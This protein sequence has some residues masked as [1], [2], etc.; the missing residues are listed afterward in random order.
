[1]NYLLIIFSLS[2]ILMACSGGDD[3]QVQ[4]PRVTQQS[5][6]TPP[7]SIDGPVNPANIPTGIYSVDKMHTYLTFSYLHL[8]YSYPLLRVTGIDGELNLNGNSM[9]KSSV[10]MA[11]D[12]SL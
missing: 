6:I 4:Q 11:I 12:A 10:S 7:P 8:G 2:F 3:E 1:M 5:P 9:E